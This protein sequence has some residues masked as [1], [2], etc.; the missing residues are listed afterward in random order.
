MKTPV[1]ILA[2]ITIVSCSSRNDEIDF[3]RKRI[4]SLE[5]ALARSYKP[6]FGEI[7]SGV[8]IHHSKLWFAGINGNWEL[9]DFEIHELNELFDDIKVFQ[10]DR[11]E[12]KDIDMINPALKKVS[13]AVE[14]KNM[15]IFKRSFEEFTNTCNECHK[16]TKFAYNIVKVPSRPVFDNQEFKIEK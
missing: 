12:S 16:I 2:L 11:T 5:T 14:R 3:L 8:Q 15:N 7:M 1:L 9:A 4:D 6:G 13:V 10:S